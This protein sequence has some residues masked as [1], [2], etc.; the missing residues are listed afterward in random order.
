MGIDFH[1]QQAWAEDTIMTE[2]TQK[3]WP[4]PFCGIFCI[5][6]LL[7]MVSFAAVTQRVSNNDTGLVVFVRLTFN[8]VALKEKVSYF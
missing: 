4:S 8:S 3:K 7:L 6:V 5:N 1:P 2:C